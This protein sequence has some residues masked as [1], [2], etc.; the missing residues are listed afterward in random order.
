MPDQFPDPREEDIMVGDRRLSRPDSALPDWHIPDASYRPIPIAWFAA[1]FLL[2]MIVLFA[3]F[4]ILIVQPGWVTIML[5]ILAT[6]AIG[7]WTWNRGMKNA[8]AGWRIATIVML[9]AQ[10]A[11]VCLGAASRV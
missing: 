11:L 3:L 1:A 10:L 2:Q 7:L 9:A 4:V 6:G 8:G 5:S